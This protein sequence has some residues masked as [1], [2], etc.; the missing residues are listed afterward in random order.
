MSDVCVCVCGVYLVY[1][2]CVVCMYGV[3]VWCV[4]VDSSSEGAG[5]SVTSDVLTAVM[6]TSLSDSTVAP[7]MV[8]LCLL[9]PLWLSNCGPQIFSGL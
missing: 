7:V 9:Y 5:S 3:C 8:R 2:M 6:R 1:V 4:C